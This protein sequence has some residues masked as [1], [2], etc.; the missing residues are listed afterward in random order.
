MKAWK[1]WTGAELLLTLADSSPLPLAVKLTEYVIQHPEKP[2]L[3]SVK[4]AGDWEDLTE[5]AD[6]A[7]SVCS[8]VF[9]WLV[10]EDLFI[11]NYGSN[12]KFPEETPGQL[13]AVQL[14]CSCFFMCVASG[15]QTRP[16][17]VCVGLCQKVSPNITDSYHYHFRHPCSPSKPTN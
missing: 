3:L 10:R 4:T 1:F 7:H 15:G 2:E 16:K 8:C 6:N 5:E 14:I 12:T 13:A 17:H 9:A 11:S